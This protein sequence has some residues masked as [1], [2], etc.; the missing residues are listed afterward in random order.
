[1]GT[2][3]IIKPR[4]ILIATVSTTVVIGAAAS[5]G[6]AGLALSGAHN[7][8]YSS[9]DNILD[10]RDE[11]NSQEVNS[12]PTEYDIPAIQRYWQKRPAEVVLRMTE[13]S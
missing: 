4:N 12:L 9:H 13:V 2:R 5:L 8:V 6:L 1:M 7:A 10:S 3:A 11:L